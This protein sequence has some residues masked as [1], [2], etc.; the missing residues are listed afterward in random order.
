MKKPKPMK[1]VKAWAIIDKTGKLAQISP[2]RAMV[3]INSGV[4]ERI[5]RVE[6][7]E[8]VRASKGN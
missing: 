3:H 4:G 1:P 8:V 2:S 7:R 5:A 6:I